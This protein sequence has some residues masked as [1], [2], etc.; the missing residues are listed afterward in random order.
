[1]FKINAD[2]MYEMKVDTHTYTHS[3]THAHIYSIHFKPPVWNKGFSFRLK[4]SKYFE[5]LH[6]SVWCDGVCYPPLLFCLSP[7]PTPSTI[8]S[9]H[10]NRLRFGWLRFSSSS[11]LLRACIC[12][13]DVLKSNVNVQH[14]NN[15]SLSLKS[16]FR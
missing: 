11:L 5:G 4:L 15:S 12:M 1:M 14:F 7:R 3:Y 6:S 8:I 13:Y 16:L 9:P 10:F 2:W